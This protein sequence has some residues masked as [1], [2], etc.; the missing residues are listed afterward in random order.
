MSSL[1]LGKNNE[2]SPDRLEKWKT[3]IEPGGLVT[4]DR[5]VMQISDMSGS[6]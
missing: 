2:A 5:L 3:E 4:P 1:K 6:P